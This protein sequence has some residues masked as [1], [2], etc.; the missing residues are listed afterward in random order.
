ML[1]CTAFAF[2][3]MLTIY[4][5][6]LGLGAI[7]GTKFVQRNRRPVS[8]F[9]SAANVSRCVSRDC[10]SSF[11]LAH[12]RISHSKFVD[13]LWSSRSAEREPRSQWHFDMVA[14]SSAA[15]GHVG[16]DRTFCVVPGSCAFGVNP[17]GH[18]PDGFKFSLS[19]EGNSARHPH[20]RQ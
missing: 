3:T 11:G 7:A 4:L 14:K 6:G 10:D 5:G 9:F 8:V 19:A 18:D 2:G 12:S 1:K 15:T 16:G 13:L 20:N 17:T